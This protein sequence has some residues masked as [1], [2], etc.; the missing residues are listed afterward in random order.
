MDRFLSINVLLGVNTWYLVSFRGYGRLI[1]QKYDVFN[2]IQFILIV[3]WGKAWLCLPPRSP[4]MNTRTGLAPRTLPVHL[5]STYSCR[6][7]PTC[8]LATTHTNLCS[9]APACTLAPSPALALICAWATWW[10]FH[11][12]IFIQLSTS[13]KWILSPYYDMRNCYTS[14]CKWKYYKCR[15]NLKVDYPLLCPTI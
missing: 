11:Y 8:T 13:L 2:S 7:V 10:N 3:F 9:L 14:D 5:M 15:K 12:L 6:F 1:L 4:D